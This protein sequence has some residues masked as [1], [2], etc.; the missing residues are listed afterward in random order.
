MDKCLYKINVKKFIIFDKIMLNGIIV[1][2][3]YNNI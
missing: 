2:K 3:I 1:Y